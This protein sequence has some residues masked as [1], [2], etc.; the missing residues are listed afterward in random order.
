MGHKVHPIGLRLAV[1][2]DWEAKWYAD[3][4]YAEFLREDVKLRE[5]IRSK[6]PEA[7]IS[8]MEIDRQAKDVTITVCK[9]T[10]K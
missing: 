2:R 10:H 4:Q 5:A 8:T 9:T 3:A 1:I 7:A 6:Y